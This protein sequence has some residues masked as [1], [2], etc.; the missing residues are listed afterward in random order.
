MNFLRSEEVLLQKTE[1]TALQNAEEFVSYLFI[2]IL[3]TW[4]VSC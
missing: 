4:T 1:N 2:V 3:A